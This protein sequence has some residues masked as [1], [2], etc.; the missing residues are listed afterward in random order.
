MNAETMAYYRPN[1]ETRV[2]VDASLVGLGAILV[3]KQK[4]GSDRPVSYGSRA[5]TPAEQ[6]FSQTEREA[7]A[8][9]F[10]CTH[11]HFFIYDRR[12]TVITVIKA[13]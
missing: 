9:L 7:L 13:Y 8:V 5:L 4:D 1:A 3:Q 12:F 11:F 2:I 10:G 6:R